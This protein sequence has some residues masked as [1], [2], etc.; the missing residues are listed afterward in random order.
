M[1]RAVSG[2]I[3][4]LVIAACG[5]A[6]EEQRAAAATPLDLRTGD[7]QLAPEAQS[8]LW[9]VE[10]RYFPLQDRVAPAL[11]DAL[12]RSDPAPWL[13]MLAPGFGGVV[14]TGEGTHTSHPPVSEW[15]WD[16]KTHAMRRLGANAW[17]A[18]L[19]A[20][21]RGFTTLDEASVHFDQLMPIDRDRLSGEWQGSWTVRLAGRIPDGSRAEIEWRHDLRYSSM[22]TDPEADAGWLRTC[23]PTRRI[24]RRAP[25]PLMEE[26]TAKTGIDTAAMLDNW[27]WR[28]SRNV[29]A[30]FAT[31]MLDYDQDGR[32]DVLVLDRRPWLWRGLG[33]GRFEDA[34]R[35]AHLP[36]G[37]QAHFALA[38]VADF[39]NDG[40]P[41][42]LMDVARKRSWQREAYRNDGG[43][44]VRL[45]DDELDMPQVA[46]G[47]GAVADFDGDGLLDL[48]LPNAGALPDEDEK[49]ERWIGDWSGG[50]G[51]LLR[52]RGG[53]RFEDVTARAGA[54]AGHRDVFVALWLDIEPDGDPDL[55]LGNHFGDNVVLRNRGDGTFEER[56]DK[57]RFG[58]FTMGA[59][60]G[61]LDGDGDPDLYLANMSSRAGLRIL[62]NLRP[63]DFPPGA[64]SLIQGFVEG[65]AV[66]RNNGAEL[67]TVALHTAGWAYGPAMVDL[68]GDGRLD[69]YSPAGFQSVQR[70]EPDG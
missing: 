33:D 44:F 45:T 9:A 8:L 18:R 63:Q 36:E 26:I 46:V 37:K 6:S 5:P 1:T 68:D 2:S 66:V 60:A 19:M 12:R 54:A 40:D 49:R 20:A 47:N 16:A 55:F 56:V 34:T 7:W 52:N 10:N 4:S 39:D 15:T 28:G 23:T 62:A 11:G 48:Y 31:Y 57:R 38:T 17:V 67:E 41:D 61:D 58:G 69:L 51:V 21:R 59:T 30:S 3:L 53:F 13:H 50:E 29:I 24:V 27:T 35:K 25:G 42:L 22:P 70:G 43:V 65:N 64:F 14:F 32:L